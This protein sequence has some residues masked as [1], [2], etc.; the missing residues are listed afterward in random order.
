[1]PSTG[2]TAPGAHEAGPP[3]RL[4]VATIELP[5]RTGPHDPRD[6]PAR[7]ADP[8]RLAPRRPEAPRGLKALFLS[9][10]I[11]CMPSRY[12][13]FGTVFAEAMLHGLPCVGSRAYGSEVII[14][15]VTGWLVEAGDVTAWQPC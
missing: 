11:F 7:L 14:E 13:P 9:S 5:M 6:A 4:P 12:E 10:D 8:V 2:V 15:G 1:M 3:C